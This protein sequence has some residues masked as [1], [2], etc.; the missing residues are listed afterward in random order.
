MSLYTVCL[1]GFGFSPVADGSHLL[2]GQA[3]LHPYPSSSRAKYPARRARQRIKQLRHHPPRRIGM[4][5]YAAMM[6]S[7]WS[8]PRKK[9]LCPLCTCSTQPR[10][11]GS[12]SPIRFQMRTTKETACASASSGVTPSAIRETALCSF[13]MASAYENVPAFP[14]EFSACTAGYLVTIIHPYCHNIVTDVSQ[15]CHS[16]VENSSGE[17]RGIK[18]RG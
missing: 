6:D 7:N 9:V 15:E 18:E 2:V 14:G 4:P 5:T 1:G 8:S 3:V 11:S 10:H 12:A 16:K 13:T 17:T